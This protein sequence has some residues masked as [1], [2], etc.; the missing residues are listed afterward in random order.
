LTLLTNAVVTWTSD[1]L[2]LAVGAMRAEGRYVNGE[3]LACGS[4]ARSPVSPA[5]ASHVWWCQPALV[6]VPATSPV[7]GPRSC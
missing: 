7:V 4:S 1:Y 2:E 6:T 3:A 5:V